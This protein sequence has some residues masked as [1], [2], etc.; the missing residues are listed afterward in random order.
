MTCGSCAARVEKT[1]NA[2]P[3][4]EASVNFA[5]GEALVRRSVGAPTLDALV[6]AV[7]ARGYELTPHV[8]RDAAAAEAEARAWRTRLLLAWVLGVATMVVSMIS[9]HDAWARWTAFALAAPVQFVAG[10]PFVVGAVRRARAL[11]EIGR[12][13]V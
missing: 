11:T 6:E 2:Q 3:G 7:R 13:H 5:T 9:M 8:D 12:A 10:W 1:L 4:V